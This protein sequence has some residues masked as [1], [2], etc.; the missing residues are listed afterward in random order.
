VQLP[1][2]QDPQEI[3]RI[4][5]STAKMTFHLVDT[6]IDP[7]DMAAGR[8]PDGTEIV[9]SQTGKI[10]YPIEQEPLLQSDRLVDASSGFDPRTG[11]PI[12]SFRLDWIGTKRF[13]DITRTHVGQPFAIVLDGNVLSAPVI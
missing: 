3:K 8:L 9:P 6:T 2:V 11:L 13:A 5:V 1:G 10:S 7:A 4:L 12:V